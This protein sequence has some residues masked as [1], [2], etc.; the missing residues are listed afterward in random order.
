MVAQATLAQM[1]EAVFQR[2]QPTKEGDNSGIRPFENPSEPETKPE[3][4][5]GQDNMKGSPS[6]DSM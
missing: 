5:E 1:I 4:S 3:A 2:I 6:V